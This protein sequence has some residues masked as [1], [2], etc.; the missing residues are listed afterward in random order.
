MQIL[1]SSMVLIQMD[2]LHD[3]RRDAV[4]SDSDDDILQIQS[5]FR[6]HMARQD[7]L[8]GRRFVIIETT[9]VAFPT[10]R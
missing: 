8:K 7:R 5:A 9:R 3:R 10:I 6:S 1:S 4:D 2:R